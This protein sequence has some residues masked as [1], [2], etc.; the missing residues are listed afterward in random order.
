MTCR[1]FQIVSLPHHRARDMSNATVVRRSGNQ[2]LVAKWK[3]EG[4]ISEKEMEELLHLI[5]HGME[6][7]ES[8]LK[9]K[10]MNNGEVSPAASPSKAPAV[11]AVEPNPVAAQAIRA[12][13]ADLMSN[14]KLVLEDA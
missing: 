7:S 1:A 14:H 13:F 5:K 3:R 10:V 4:V 2:D 11:V 6:Q 8:L 12:R 9:K